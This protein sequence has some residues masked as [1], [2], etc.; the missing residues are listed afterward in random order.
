MLLREGWR[1]GAPGRVHAGRQAGSKLQ[2]RGRGRAG[3]P[4]GG[5]S[6][7]RRGRSRAGLP[8]LSA[9]R[10]PAGGGAAEAAAEAGGRGGGARDW[11][12]GRQL[13][14]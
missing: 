2:G 9:Q 5:A 12:G 8:G 11:G 6:W 1:E 10:G 14:P 13:P 4:R 3:G 7:R